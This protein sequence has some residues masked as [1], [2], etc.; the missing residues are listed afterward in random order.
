MCDDSRVLLTRLRKSQV[1]SEEGENIGQ[2]IGSEFMLRYF[3]EIVVWNFGK[4]QS[5]PSCRIDLHSDRKFA[6][7]GGVAGMRRACPHGL[8]VSFKGI[9]HRAGRRGEGQASCV[10]MMPI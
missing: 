4:M 10:K 8:R 1:Q 7:G 9:S 6:P 5:A 3:F 2:C